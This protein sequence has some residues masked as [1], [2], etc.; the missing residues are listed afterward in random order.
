M[1]PSTTSVFRAVRQI[2]FDN[3][4][5]EHAFCFSLDNTVD[6]GPQQLGELFEQ[7]SDFFMAE[8][9][10]E[11]VTKAGPG[12]TTPRRMFAGLDLH[13]MTKD[14]M[15]DL[16]AR[17]KLEEIAGWFASQTIDGIR[18]REYAPTGDGELIGFVRYSA[19]IPFECELEPR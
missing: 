16:G 9:E 7:A 3:A 8:I 10:V 5:P 1:Y 18:F 2:I 4:T 13:F 14:R 11:T 17:D 6:A 19:T 12:T 15:D